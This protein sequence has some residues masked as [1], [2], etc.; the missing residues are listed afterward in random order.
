MASKE[1][2]E[3]ICHQRILVLLRTCRGCA[4]AD[5]LSSVAYHP[6]QHGNTESFFNCQLLPAAATPNR[7]HKSSPNRT[8]KISIKGFQPF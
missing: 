6:L 8:E 5:L 4:G 2:P 7:R 1:W 3:N